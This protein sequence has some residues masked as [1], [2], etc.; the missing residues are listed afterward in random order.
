MVFLPVLNIKYTNTI[1]YDL[2]VWEKSLMIR[3]I[4]ISTVSLVNNRKIR[5]LTYKSI[6][7]REELILRNNIAIDS[8][9][10]LVAK[11]TPTSLFFWS[12]LSWDFL[13]LY[14]PLAKK[15]FLPVKIQ[16]GDWISNWNI[17]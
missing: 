9:T 15:Q 10:F 3:D 12:N 1:K 5:F 17:V 8:I 16:K 11:Q 7:Y 13:V 2:F 4:Q 6:I 14:A